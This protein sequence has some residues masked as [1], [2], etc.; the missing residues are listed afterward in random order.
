MRRRALVA[1]ALWLGIVALWAIFF[2]G[3]N[4]YMCLGPMGVTEESCRAAH[5]LPPLTDWDRFLRGGG[6]EAIILVAG[7]LAIVV[8]AVAS[9]RLRQRGGL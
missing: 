5:G 8:V 7:W 1:G 9:D 6:A 2:H 4:V 3:G